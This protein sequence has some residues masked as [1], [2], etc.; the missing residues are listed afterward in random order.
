MR[1]RDGVA[2]TSRSKIS[3]AGESSGTM[4]LADWATLLS[5]QL[6]WERGLPHHNSDLVVIAKRLVTSVHAGQD[7]A[8]YHR[9]DIKVPFLEIHDHEAGSL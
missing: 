2:A 6:I 3:M 1:E 4:P 9:R 8:G 7:N 5:T